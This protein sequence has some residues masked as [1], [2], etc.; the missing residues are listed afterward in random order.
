MNV[1]IPP[2]PKVFSKAMKEGQVDALQRLEDLMMLADRVHHLARDGTSHHGTSEV[3]KMC[4]PSNFPV[5]K[6]KLEVDEMTLKELREEWRGLRSGQVLQM[7]PFESEILELR[8][9][10]VEQLHGLQ[11]IET[12]HTM[13][14][15]LPLTEPSESE[16][17]TLGPLEKL[18]CTFQGDEMRKLLEN[19]TTLTDLR[20][21]SCALIAVPPGGHIFPQHFPGL[22][23][24]GL[25]F[26]LFLT[27]SWW[28]AEDH[29]GYLEIFGSDMSVATK[30]KPQGWSWKQRQTKWEMFQM[31][32]EKT[33]VGWII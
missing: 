13:A 8:D 10:L 33:L 17:E 19:I 11:A 9:E 31:S 12:Q 27:E 28:N 25:G 16:V 18:R 14:F 20:S 21:P 29:G 7:E 4:K 5:E 26:T 30:V 6:L 3:E 32:N 24:K 22:F 2:S 1:G 23:N 15:V